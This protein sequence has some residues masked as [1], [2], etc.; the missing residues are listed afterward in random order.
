MIYSVFV[1]ITTCQVFYIDAEDEEDAKKTVNEM[2]ESDPYYY[3]EHPHTVVDWGITDCAL[4]D[5][6]EMKELLRR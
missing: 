1:D 5:Q 3:A 6:E 2:I 4:E